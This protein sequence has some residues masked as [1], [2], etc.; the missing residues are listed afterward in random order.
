MLLRGER[1]TNGGNQ[2][3]LRVGE[4]SQRKDAVSTIRLRDIVFEVRV[5]DK[6]I[7]RIIIW[8][9][10]RDRLRMREHYELKL[11]E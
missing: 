8:P 3:T 2:I 10:H 11:A 6:T 4:A 7:E 1:K 9:V 5:K